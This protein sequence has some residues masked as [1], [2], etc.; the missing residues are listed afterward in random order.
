[1][2]SP[3]LIQCFSTSQTAADP[4]FAPIKAEVARLEKKYSRYLPDSL[5][6]QINQQAGFDQPVTIDQETH[7][8][9]QFAH[10]AYALS[11]GLFDI[12]SGVLRQAWDFK[13]GTVPTPSQLA[14]VLPLIGWSKVQWNEQQITL[15]TKG[16]E[17]DLGGIVKEYAVDRCVALLT[18]AKVKALINLGGDIGVTATPPQDHVW[19]VGIRHPRKGTNDRIG[20]IPLTHG[21][22]AASGDYERCILLNGKRYNHILNPKTG[23]PI[24]G[25]A[26]VCIWA[27]RCVLAGTLTTIAMLK[28][29]SGPNW[30]KA[31]DMPYMAVDYDMQVYGGFG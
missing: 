16:M 5:L 1:M 2:G 7:G 9:L 31:L 4:I 8:I 11:D 30:L 26:T 19:D 22:I 27:E 10:Q 6:S 25:L 28:G 3:C 20:S 15:P 12:T 23:Y 24:E 17:I 21:A 29:P 14:S 13:T 18:E